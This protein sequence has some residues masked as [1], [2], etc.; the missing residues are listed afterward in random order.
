MKRELGFAP[1]KLEWL[2]DA[3][4]ALG[5]HPSN[6]TDSGAVTVRRHFT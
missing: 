3:K 1:R 5:A 4:A 6:V 2:H